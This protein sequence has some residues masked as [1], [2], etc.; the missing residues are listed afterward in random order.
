MPLQIRR[1][2]YA[3]TAMGG[4]GVATIIDDKLRLGA[5]VLLIRRL[6]VCVGV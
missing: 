3:G 4:G 2:T 5:L 1:I 6:C